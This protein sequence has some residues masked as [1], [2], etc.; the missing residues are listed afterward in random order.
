[1]FYA[2]FTSM[3]TMPGVIT[4]PL[5]MGVV[6]DG[7]HIVRRKLIDRRLARLAKEEKA[8]RVRT[9]ILVDSEINIRGNV[10]SGGKS[11]SQ[12]IKY[13]IIYETGI[14]D[15]DD[16]HWVETHEHWYFGFD[17]FERFQW[18]WTSVFAD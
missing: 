10:P 4:P 18:D 9:V 8:G 14:G 16:R 17:N 6:V 12:I 15:Q 7:D 3:H 11:A 13:E 2:A 5:A 1:M